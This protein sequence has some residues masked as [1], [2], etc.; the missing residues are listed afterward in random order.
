MAR[1]V[2]NCS[3]CSLQ[4]LTSASCPECNGFGQYFADD[5]YRHGFRPLDA[6]PEQMWRRAS[7]TLDPGNLE[8]DAILARARRLFEL[9]WTDEE[10]GR[11]FGWTKAMVQN[12]LGTRHRKPRPIDLSDEDVRDINEMRAKGMTW[13]EIAPLYQTTPSGLND[14][15]RR[16]HL[17]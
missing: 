13:V 8:S 14:Y 5:R 9:G 2:V 1:V 16:R 15:I 3:R 10:I 4:G 12:R 17:R 11:E 6:T 7:P